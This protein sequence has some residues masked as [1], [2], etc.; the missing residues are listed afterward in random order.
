MLSTSGNSAPK[1]L[2]WSNPNE[3]SEC[4]GRYLF[5]IMQPQMPPRFCHF[6]SGIAR[7]LFFFLS[8][9]IRVFLFS[10][11]HQEDSSIFLS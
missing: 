1:C 5:V 7:D 10:I 2:K 3:S 8:R 4:F 11:A 6:T 9:T